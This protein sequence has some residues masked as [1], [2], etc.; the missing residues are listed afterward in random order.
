MAEALWVLSDIY[1]H[2]KTGLWHDPCTVP[3]ATKEA[4]ILKPRLI[5]TH[6]HE[7][8][9]IFVKYDCWVCPKLRQYY[10]CSA[11]LTTPIIT[12]CL[13]I[14]MN[15]NVIHFW[16]VCPFFR[17]G[18]C[19]LGRLLG[20]P[21]QARAIAYILHEQD[22]SMDIKILMKYTRQSLIQFLLRNAKGNEIQVISE[23]NLYH[24]HLAV[25]KALGCS[26]YLLDLIFWIVSCSV[27]C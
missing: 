4:S 2:R 24:F 9:R 27:L 23:I 21:A 8:R 13:T 18:D 7:H 15:L 22:K 25:I 11:W 1:K 16:L 20:V 26:I 14:S 5:A 6:V 12:F 19:S 10:L 3:S 17:G